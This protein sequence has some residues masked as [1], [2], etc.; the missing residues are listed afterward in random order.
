MDNYLR[1]NDYTT[2]KNF[3][4]KN[5]FDLKIFRPKNFFDQNFFSQDFIVDDHPRGNEFAM[6]KK[7]F[8]QKFVLKI[9]KW[10]TT[11][12]EMILRR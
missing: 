8:D 11:L 2:R 6:I 4:P 3:Q 10:V 1:G 7:N 5:F 12:E 9:F